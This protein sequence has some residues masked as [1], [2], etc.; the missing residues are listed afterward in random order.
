MTKVKG[1][2]PT[3]QRRS[4]HST[5][6]ARRPLVV[7]E[8]NTID[9]LLGRSDLRLLWLRSLIVVVGHSDKRV[10]ANLCLPDV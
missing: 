10:F 7:V 5:K 3:D 1:P 2:G 6:V 8:S 4:I 9:V